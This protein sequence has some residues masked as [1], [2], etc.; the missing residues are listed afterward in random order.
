M[1]ERVI[2]S[3]AKRALKKLPRDVREE[4][5]RSTCILET[6]PDAGTQLSGRLFSL[7]SFHFKFRNIEY[8]VAYSTDHPKKLVIIHLAHTRENFYDKLRRLFR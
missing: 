7:R 6:N 2:T 3:S 1:Y 4:L 8:R 5:L